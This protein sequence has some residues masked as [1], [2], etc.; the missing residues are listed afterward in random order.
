FHK[1]PNIDKSTLR[2]VRQILVISDLHLSEGYSKETF[3]WN[4]RE[5]FTSDIAF[6]NFLK[7]KRENSI[8]KKH[9]TWLIINGDFIDFLRV[10]TTPGSEEELQEWRT[11]LEQITSS[12][13]PNQKERVLKAFEEF[14]QSWRINVLDGKRPKWKW[15][16]NIRDEVKYG[17][18]T[19][20]FKSIY[21]L[22][23]VSKGHSV[24]FQA[25]TKW[26]AAGHLLTIVSGNHDQEFDQELV[27][28]GFS[29][30]LETQLKEEYLKSPN[31]YTSDFSNSLTFERHG[32]EIDGKIR[33]EH[34]NRFELHTKTRDEWN[35]H[36]HQELF[37][38]PGSLFNRYLLNRVELEV[39]YLDNVKPSTRVISYLIKKRP[40]Q[41]LKMVGKLLKTAFRLVWKRGTNRLVFAGLLRLP[42]Y[43]LF[44]LY[45]LWVLFTL[46]RYDGNP[47]QKI[48][49]GPQLFGASFFPL[50][51]AILFLFG[52][53]WIIN[54]IEKAFKLY[55]SE[56][57]LKKE[58]GWPYTAE[59]LIKKQYSICGHT[60]LADMQSWENN[61]I[62]IN[63]GTWA[64]VFEYKWGH[65]CDDLS[66]TFVELNK[67]ASDW[68]AKLARWE[69]LCNQEVEV[70]LIEA[71]MKK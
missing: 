35:N 14:A 71:H 18:K 26:L 65:V 23:L 8:V 21:R 43:G 52:W 13:L 15:P 47:L 56:E 22:M 49:N 51:I 27:Q 30:I 38:A 34:G 57:E 11:T 61:T 66:M 54:K 3:H 36:E 39:P 63:T 41:F 28:A 53:V 42:Q 62:Y 69:P 67:N 19:H 25:L 2:E 32:L 9:R 40:L 1:P 12:K 70:T 68:T 64:P 10:K 6:S 60:H 44:L 33:I 4:R 50:Y 48:W 17:L 24:L 31:Q 16:R 7:A 46:F 29:W 20:D 55:F 45:L 37:L 5:N 59:N 58:L